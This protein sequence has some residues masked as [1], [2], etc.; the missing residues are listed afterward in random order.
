MNRI[1]RFLIRATTFLRK[2]IVEV[3]R[4]PR[5]V[6][7]L[8][9]GPFIIMLLFGLGYRHEARA[10]RTIFVASAD[11]PLAGQVED[12]ARSLGPQLV[13][14][15][16]LTEE[17]TA[18]AE[19]RNGRADMVVL[20]PDD[21]AQK[22]E[23]D[24]QAV[25][26][27]YHNEIDPFQVSYVEYI[28]QFYVSELN[29]R[30]LRE[31]VS[32]GQAEAGTV[33]E[34]LQA[35]RT[36]AQ[37]MRSALEVGDVATSQQELTT[38]NQNMDLMTAA[39]GAS[40]GLLE[41]AQQTASGDSTDSNEEI[42][43]TLEQINQSRSELGNVQADDQT[44]IS[45][46]IQRLNE[47]DANLEKLD[48]LLSKFREIQPYILVNP[49]GLESTSLTGVTLTPTDFFTPAV[50][51]LLLHHLAV[52]F[53]ALSIVRENAS[54]AMELFRVSP[55]S[56]F[57]TLL[58]KYLSYMLFGG[59]LAVLISLL[60]VYGLG[61]PMAGDW[62]DYAITLAALL[63][64]A[65]GAGFIISL[66]SETDTQAVQYS[67]LL[68]LASIFFTGFFLDLRLMVSALNLLSG[69]LP[70]THG[71]RL[72]QNIML[73]GD[74]LNPIWIGGLVMIGVALF[75]LSWILLRRRMSQV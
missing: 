20:V 58:G 43:A 47:I 2:E 40:V 4:Q 59:I 64:A 14:Q 33:Q 53:A 9:L 3:I 41:N 32:E 35:A 72:L 34:N 54:G 57:E 18:R 74:N 50:I 70:A 19:L 8:V 44:E 42:T 28:G 36:S 69:I 38:F 26:Q 71:I 51:I 1:F 46:E 17:A 12:F 7:L 13:Y 61:V 37:A 55:I 49:F 65:L 29:K 45:A 62:G 10:L 66:I 63:F 67:M 75:I 6:L 21:A 22:L 27:M 68:L 11:N 56:A 24:E 5:L 48:G 23:N 60:V 39:I 73:R 15:G 25:F 16:L 30:V 52:T 31:L